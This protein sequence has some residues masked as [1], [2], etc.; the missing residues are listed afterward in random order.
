MFVPVPSH[1][2]AMIDAR[3]WKNVN[4]KKVSEANTL[5]LPFT[6]MNFP[7]YSPERLIENVK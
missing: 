4:K 5:P 7:R 3:V 1:P 2:A 6:G